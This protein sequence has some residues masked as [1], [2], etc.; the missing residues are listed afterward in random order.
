[1]RQMTEPMIADHLNQILKR[2]ITL[3][4]AVWSFWASV[5]AMSFTPAVSSPRLNP[6]R[7]ISMID[8]YMP[9]MPIPVG[10]NN[11]AI[12]LVR[13]MPMRIIN[14]WDPPKMVVDFIIC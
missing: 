3:L 7:I 12:I 1:M 10:P 5:S 8:W 13:M 6:D 2:D 11:M 4:R 14:A 9:I